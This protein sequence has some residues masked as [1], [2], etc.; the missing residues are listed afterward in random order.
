MDS[1][2][3]SEAEIDYKSI[4]HI[5]VD[6]SP[7]GLHTRAHSMTQRNENARTKTTLSLHLTLASSTRRP[8][9]SKPRCTF[10]FVDVSRQQRQ[11]LGNRKKGKK[12]QYGCGILHWANQPVSRLVPSP[13][14]ALTD[15]LIQCPICILHTI[16]PFMMSFIHTLYI[17]P[18]LVPFTSY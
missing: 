18:R 8:T 9:D 11:K 12:T 10:W 14:V 6:M 5:M 4:T 1:G 15:A 3:K 17:E 2:Q 7:L 13:L 16:V